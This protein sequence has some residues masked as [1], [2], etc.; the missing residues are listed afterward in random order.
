M[1]H[2]ELNEDELAY[3]VDL[4]L[5]YMDAVYLKRKARPEIWTS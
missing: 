5:S 1:H 2:P 3:E 4:L